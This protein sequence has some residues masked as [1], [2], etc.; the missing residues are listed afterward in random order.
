[1][2]GPDTDAGAPD[3]I[4]GRMTHRAS[5]G[6]GVLAACAALMLAMLVGVTVVDVVG[7]YLLNAPMA[8]AYELTQIALAALVFIA[9]PMTTADDGHV[10]VDLVMH[11]LPPRVA[12][13]LGWL[14]GL[15]SACVLAYFA[16]RLAL[17]GL[18]QAHDGARTSGIRFPLAPMAFLGAASCA[19]SSLILLLRRPG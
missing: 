12:A 17:L 16:Y 2:S 18:G 10:E 4:P 5:R 6:Y 3:H 14:A 19:L 15:G 11:V 7:R 13:W 8:A 1:M 9:L